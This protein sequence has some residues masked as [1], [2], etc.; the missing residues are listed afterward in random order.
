MYIGSYVF[1]LVCMHHTENCLLTNFQKHCFGELLWSCAVSA[2]LMKLWRKLCCFYPSCQNQW[3][4]SCSQMS[5]ARRIYQCLDYMASMSSLSFTPCCLFGGDSSLSLMIPS[6]SPWSAAM[7]LIHPVA[8]VVLKLY[9]LCSVVLSF[10]RIFQ[11]YLL[12]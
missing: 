8:S 6:V 11:G 12:L 9:L 3:W 2:P 1:V 7:T 10:L 4:Q 5:F